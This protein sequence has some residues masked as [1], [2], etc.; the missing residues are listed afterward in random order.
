[1]V[2]YSD[3]LKAQKNIGDSYITICGNNKD[4]FTTFTSYLQQNGCLAF[5][6]ELD[7]VAESSV[8]GLYDDCRLLQLKV[9]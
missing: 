1:M 8:V 7:S 5:P 6:A 4:Y 9:V 3:K 2:A